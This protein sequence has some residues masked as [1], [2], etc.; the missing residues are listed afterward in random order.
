M[1]AERR[2]ELRENELSHALYVAGTYVADRGKRFGVAAVAVVLLLVLV[3]LAMRSRAAAHE[4]RW[5][6]LSRLTF[7]DPETA[8]GSLERLIALTRESSDER[9]L[10]T[11]LMDQGLRALRLSQQG[12]LHP[13]RDLNDKA[14]DAFE[15]LL[16]RFPSN[17]LAVGVARCG[18]A[19]TEEN[20]FVLTGDIVHK[21]RARQHLTAV[22]TNDILN[23][24]PF[25]RLAIDR[26]SAI[27][28]TFTDVRFALP[29]AD[30]LV[31]E[32]RE[33]SL[34]PAEI[35]EQLP[36]EKQAKIPRPRPDQ[37][38]KKIRFD[39]SGNIEVPEPSAANEVEIQEQ[40]DEVEGEEPEVN[41]ADSDKP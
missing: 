2:H 30:Q 11:V 3:S 15:Q 8:R 4:D 10:L 36:P 19:T 39:P 1:K 27:D 40:S 7:E 22:I 33:P 13:D 25:Q 17:P 21:E 14:Q 29:D 26:R 9:F 24:M 31:E 34:T 38:I 35:Y 16:T 37:T 23:G 5:R 41:E 20:L 18:L 6:E 32:L 28:A 12:P